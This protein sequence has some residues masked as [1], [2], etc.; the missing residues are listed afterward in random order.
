MFVLLALLEIKREIEYVVKHVQ[1][2]TTHKMTLYVDVSKFVTNLLMDI[3]K[4]VLIML[5]IANSPTTESVMKAPSSALM[6]FMERIPLIFALIVII[7][8]F[9]VC[10]ASQATFADELSKMCVRTCPNNPNY[11]SSPE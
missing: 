4:L 5:L 10:P 9:L 11:T 7:F 1:R 3:R 2:H 8:I 6:V